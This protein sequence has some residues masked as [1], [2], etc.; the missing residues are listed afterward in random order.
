MVAVISFVGKD[1]APLEVSVEMVSG[2][3]YFMLIAGPQ[4]SADQMTGE[5]DHD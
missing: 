4:E 1:E 5:I 3:E 2:C